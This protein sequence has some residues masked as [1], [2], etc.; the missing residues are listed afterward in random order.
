LPDAEDKAMKALCP[1]FSVY[2][3]HQHNDTTNKNEYQ[4]IADK[5]VPLYRNRNQYG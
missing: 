5:I 2:L 4:A 1:A 3:H